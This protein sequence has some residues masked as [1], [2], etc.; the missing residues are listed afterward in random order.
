MRYILYLLLFVSSYLAADAIDSE[1]IF[2]DSYEGFL[3]SATDWYWAENGVQSVI[4]FTTPEVGSE[5]DQVQLN[6]ICIEGGGGDCLLGVLY[7]KISQD[8]NGNKFYLVKDQ[9]KN[10]VWIKMNAYKTK[11]FEEILMNKGG[12]DIIFSS[13][14]E[15]TDTS[16]SDGVPDT[17]PERNKQLKKILD[18][19][20]PELGAVHVVVPGDKTVLKVKDSHLMPAG[21]F[22][23]YPL[24]KNSYYYEEENN[25]YLI[26]T[27]MYKRKGDYMVVALNSEPDILVEPALTVSEHECGSGD[28]NYVWLDTKGLEVKFIKTAVS[29]PPI[30][31]LLGE[32]DRSYSVKEIKLFNGEHYALIEEHLR[33][34]NPF[35][36]P[37][38]NGAKSVDYTILYKWIK[39]RDKKG[40]LRVWF[41]DFSC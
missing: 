32:F 33:V 3:Y 14:F 22:S 36:V 13:F 27:T 8:A 6:P 4:S 23:N 17:E 12:M 41:G 21:N 26:N 38:S 39:I 18:N 9:R 7:K 10:D 28:W 11:N 40:R 24:A 16:N 20:S 31:F 35:V 2:S 37:D 15:E 34:I 5:S 1:G 29:Y 19:F 30:E 25:T